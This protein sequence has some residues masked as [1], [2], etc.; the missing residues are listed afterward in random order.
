MCVY[1]DPGIGLWKFLHQY[2]LKIQ[3]SCCEMNTD[4]NI[5]CQHIGTGYCL[6]IDLVLGQQQAATPQNIYL[7]VWMYRQNIY[8]HP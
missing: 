2:F 8:S 5:D 3:G 6:Q 4:E 1:I 7:Q